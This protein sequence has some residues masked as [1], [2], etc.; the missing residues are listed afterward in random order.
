[1]QLAGV[2]DAGDVGAGECSYIPCF[3]DEALEDVAVLRELGAYDLYS[4]GAAEF[5]VRTFE[6]QTH[7]TRAQEPPDAVAIT[8]DLPS[9]KRTAD[10][11]RG[12]S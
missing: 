4:Y 6:N 10:S 3:V 9:R 5:D 2:E 8:D 7:A 1:M 11:T 12:G